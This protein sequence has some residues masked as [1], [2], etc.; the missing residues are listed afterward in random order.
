MPKVSIGVSTYNRRDFLRQSLK[1]L[2]NQTFRD[3]EIIVIDDGSTD[4][5]ADMVAREFPAV[6]CFAKENGGDASAKNLAAAKAGGEY[7]V[8]NDSDDLFLPDALETLLRPLEA[9]PDACSYGNY[10]GI[11]CENNRLPPRQKVSI[12]PSGRIVN[13]LI[14]HIVV[15]NCGFMMK[16]GD[17]RR[18]G[19]FDCS[20]RVAY[21]YKFVLEMAL[22][23][24]F[25]AVNKPVF[26]RRRHE[27]NLSR[28]EYRKIAVIEALIRDFAARHRDNPEIDPAVVRHRLARLNVQLAREARSEH[29]DAKIVKRHLAEALR[30]EFTLK[31]FLRRLLWR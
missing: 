20:M 3:F 18:I 24:N 8:F 10:I 25:Y 9:D 7:L 30:N 6:R 2:E 28:T 12:Y 31:S 26:L 11:D 22:E 29:L 13:D 17:F 14:R 1:S 23:R 16:T 27:G 4:G 21:D 15:C 5:T 19:G